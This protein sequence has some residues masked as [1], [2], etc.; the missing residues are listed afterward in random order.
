M[1]SKGLIVVIA[2]LLSLTL[3][4][5]LCRIA[6]M[7]FS[8]FLD[9]SKSFLVSSAWYLDDLV[10]AL[11]CVADEWLAYSSCSRIFADLFMLKE[12]PVHL[13]LLLMPPR[14]MDADDIVGDAY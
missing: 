11:G 7:I 14:L 13:M 3:L 12:A 6:C 10:A 5:L 4:L 1:N 9:L 8:A 2:C